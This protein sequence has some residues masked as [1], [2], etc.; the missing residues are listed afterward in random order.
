MQFSDR[1]RS[2]KDK[3][4]SQTARRIHQKEGETRECCEDQNGTSAEEVK[5]NKFPAR[6]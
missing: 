1:A 2:W 5:R 4:S 6:K 3:R